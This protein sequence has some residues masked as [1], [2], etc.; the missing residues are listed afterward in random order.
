MKKI[1]I[2]IVVL[3]VIGAAIAFYMA[4]KPLDKVSS[5]KT[6]TQITASELLNAFE[7]NESEANELFLDKVIEVKGVVSN[8][9]MHDDGGRTVYLETGNP[10][11]S[12]MCQQS[13][14]D[15][16]K[17]TVGDQVTMKGVCSGYLTD[18]VLVRSIIKQ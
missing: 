5:L 4:N 12:I 17:V 7:A 16:Q 11:S 3:G 15:K 13:Q 14:E 10:M 9:E 8:V 6:D 2:S 18:V 1:I